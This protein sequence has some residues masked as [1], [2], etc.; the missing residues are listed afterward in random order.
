MLSSQSKA[1]T[2]KLRRRTLR[3]KLS[4]EAQSEFCSTA[5]EAERRRRDEEEEEEESLEVAAVAAAKQSPK[6]PLSE[7]VRLNNNKSK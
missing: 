2:C 3:R 1:N 4:E 5:R 6:L 7:H